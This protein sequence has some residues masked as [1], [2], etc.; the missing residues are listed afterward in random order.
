M[1]GFSTLSL[2][3]PLIIQSDPRNV[4]KTLAPKMRPSR[5]EMSGSCCLSALLYTRRFK[6]PVQK[7]AA[8]TPLSLCKDSRCCWGFGLLYLLL[9]R[10][11]LTPAQEGS[12]NQVTAVVVRASVLFQLAH[13]QCFLFF[14]FPPVPPLGRKVLF[15]S[16]KKAIVDM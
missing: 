15:T 11:V 2:D 13:G 6:V 3:C 9:A 5:H 7:V 10:L 1:D 8:V 14:L 16:A 4:R 12:P